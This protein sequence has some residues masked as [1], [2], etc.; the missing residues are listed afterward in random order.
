MFSMGIAKDSGNRLVSITLPGSGIRVPS[1]YDQSSSTVATNFLTTLA[2]SSSVWDVFIY[3][4]RLLSGGDIPGA[5]AF[6]VFNYREPDFGTNPPSVQLRSHTF[7]SN[8]PIERSAGWFRLTALAQDD[9]AVRNV[10]FYLDGKLVFDDGSHPFEAD[11][12]APDL[13]V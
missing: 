11:L 2:T 8:P 6:E 1:V 4:G 5:G 12:R 7:F 13:S 3:R 9:V 10:E